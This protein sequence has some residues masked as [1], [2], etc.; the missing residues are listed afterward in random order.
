MRNIQKK[1]KN[2]EGDD[3]K[4]FDDAA[5]KIVVIQILGLPLY[6]NRGGQISF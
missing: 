3:A 4:S 1:M 2:S 6:Q 5:Q